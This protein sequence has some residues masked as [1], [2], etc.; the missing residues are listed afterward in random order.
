MYCSARFLG[1]GWWVRHAPRRTTTWTRW[2][3]DH[4]A[5]AQD[6]AA[7]AKPTSH[8]RHRLQELQLVKSTICGGGNVTYADLDPESRPS[9]A[10][11]DQLVVDLH[12]QRYL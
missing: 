7:P 5:P 4:P 6:P 10:S 12:Q 8:R 3:A 1:L 11:L 2:A 9:L